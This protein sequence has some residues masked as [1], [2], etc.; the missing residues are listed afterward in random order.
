MIFYFTAA[1]IEQYGL[2]LP[3]TLEPEASRPARAALERESGDRFLEWGG[4]LF[5]FEH[6]K[7]L[8][9]THFASKLTFVLVDFKKADMEKLENWMA[10][11]LLDLYSGNAEMQQLLRR[12]FAEAP[13][14]V[15]AQLR[16]RKVISTLNHTQLVFL[17]NG[18]RLQYYI[19][20]GVLN[21]H[22]LN[23]ELNREWVFTRK[24]GNRVLYY[25]S[26]ERF[27]QLLRERYSA[28]EERMMPQ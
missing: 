21:T 12:Y 26:G 5:W 3:E 1:T 9:I 20:D 4:K 6:R 27:A 13:R 8:Q 25:R 10:H 11:Y 28:P 22:E 17:D 24:E 14:A 2:K 16:D 23:R 19:H 18:R 7:C 15:I